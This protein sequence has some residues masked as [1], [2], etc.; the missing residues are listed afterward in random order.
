MS[1][2][3]DRRV[4][5]TKKQLRQGLAALLAEKPIKNITVRE[6]SD[7][8]DI[9][10]GTFYLHYKDIFDMVEQIQNEMFEELSTILDLHKE[11]R[12]NREPLPLLIAIFNYLAENAQMASVLMSKNGDASFIGK[13][14]DMMKEKLIDD[15]TQIFQ[16]K[17]PVYF[18][19]AFSFIMSGCI[20]L[21]KTWLDGGM[22]ETPEEIAQLTY[23]MVVN[24]LPI[25]M[26]G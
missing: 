3:V 24:G 20:G 12:L 23:T 13:F 6:I 1:E 8:V 26:N 19:Y 9:N 2:I 5:K 15:W 11:N 7:L 25:Q 22:S 18:H 16:V 14:S 21:F 4:R 17:N 10:R